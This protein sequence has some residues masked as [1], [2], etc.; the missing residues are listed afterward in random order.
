MVG[1]TSTPTTKVC[2]NL[3]RV[4]VGFEIHASFYMLFLY[5]DYTSRDKTTPHSSLLSPST[6]CPFLGLNPYYN[7][8]K[9]QMADLIKAHNDLLVQLRISSTLGTV[10]AQPGFWVGRS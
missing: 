2:F 3:L 1:P 7:L 5:A 4:F 9:A 10:H 6:L 8:T